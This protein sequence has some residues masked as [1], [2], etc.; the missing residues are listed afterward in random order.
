MKKENKGSFCTMYLVRHGQTEWNEKRITQG[1]S[2]SPISKIGIRQAER[3][4]EQFKHIEFCAI[5]A[6]DLSMAHRTAEIIKLN[7]KLTI[8]KSQLL[9]G[10]SYGKFEG[11]H[12]NVYKNTV[13]SKLEERETLPENEYSSFRLAP[14]IETDEE[15]ITRVIKKLKEIAAM[16][17]NG[18]VLIV[19]HGGCIKNFLIKI[20][21]MDRKSLSEGSFKHGGYMKLLSDG[22]N[23]FIKEIE[24]IK[25]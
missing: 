13:K 19:T 5:Y 22:K 2:E 21:N 7:R 10:R 12:V 20:G 6:S 25:K 18:N 15:I 16:H 14:F 8:Q 1:Q 9:R 4:G 23:F 11:K 24:G 3:V 17:L